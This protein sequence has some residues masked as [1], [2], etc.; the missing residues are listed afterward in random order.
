[1][2]VMETQ[3]EQSWDQQSYKDEFSGN[4]EFV[5]KKCAPINP[6]VVE[7]FNGL[8]EKCYLVVVLQEKPEDHR[9]HQDLSSGQHESLYK[10]LREYFQ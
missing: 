3:E 2:D 8:T 1:M 10:I 6:I 5:L 7:I 4:H 9:S